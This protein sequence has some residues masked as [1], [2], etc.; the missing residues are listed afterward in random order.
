MEQTE[1]HFLEAG[2][3]DKG[4]NIA[5]LSG[6]RMVP[7]ARV[8]VVD[9][10]PTIRALVAK[11]L[12]RAGLRVDCARDGADAI[13]NFRLHDYAVVV[14]DLM[15]PNVDGFGFIDFM[16][17][18]PPPRPAIIVISAADSGALRHLDSTIVHSILR[19]PFDIDVLGDLVLA[20]ANAILGE[21]SE[22]R[23]AENIL[24]FH[25]DNAC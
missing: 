3:I 6:G 8:L 1:G 20:A 14:L 2:C 23:P 16:K 25:R 7:E 9:D 17:R 10:E 11:I 21:Q 24:P 4:M 15:M 5:A 22:A 18:Q 12:E 19:K 13:D